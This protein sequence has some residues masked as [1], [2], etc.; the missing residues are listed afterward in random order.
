MKF[1]ETSAKMNEGVEEAFFTLARSATGSLAFLLVPSDQLL[2]RYQDSL[3]RFP[4]ECCVGSSGKWLSQG[5]PT[6]STVHTRLLF[7]NLWSHHSLPFLY[8]LFC[9]AS[10]LIL[11]YDICMPVQTSSLYTMTPYSR[12]A[13][14]PSVDCP[15]VIHWHWH[16]YTTRSKMINL[17]AF[18]WG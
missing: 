1:F 13:I 14:T 10:P 18:C 4:R 3:D 6:C 17:F 5:K 2:Q 15:S 8:K 9:V 12:N 11:Q 7:M 16:M